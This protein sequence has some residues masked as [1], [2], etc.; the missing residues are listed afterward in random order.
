[1]V[2]LLIILWCLWKL[3]CPTSSH[4]AFPYAIGET[5]SARLGKLRM[6]SGRT[7]TATAAP[8]AGS[9]AAAPLQKPYVEDVYAP[10]VATKST[11]V[12]NVVGCA[13]GD[14]SCSDMTNVPETTLSEN[15]SKAKAFATSSDTTVVYYWAPW[16]PHCTNSMGTFVSAAE[17]L[18]K[19]GVKCGI[20]NCELVSKSFIGGGFLTVTHFP[21]CVVHGPG[22]AAKVLERVS[23]DEI[24]ATALEVKTL[25]E[26]T[27]QSQESLQ[28]FF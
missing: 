27:K 26:Q 18:E 24:V 6:V 1:M 3:S 25:A 15:E 11:S 8:P 13:K 19:E 9:P 22:G 4:G 28:A 21:Y 12:T 16:C 5:I 17:D 23:K 14:S 20:V 10:S 7:A 2:F